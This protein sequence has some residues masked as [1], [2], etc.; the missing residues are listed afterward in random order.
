MQNSKLLRYTNMIILNTDT[1][2]SF[3]IIPIIQSDIDLNDIYATFK[4]ET[5]KQIIS[6]DLFRSNVKD[7]LVC[8]IE[9]LDFLTENNFYELTIKFTNTQQIIY[10]DRVFCTDQTIS[11]YS[12]NNGQYITPTIDNN[13]YITI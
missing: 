7:V 6:K 2:Q 11:S 9:D 3:S 10:K 8:V 5:T 4:N 1:E 13:S 12:I